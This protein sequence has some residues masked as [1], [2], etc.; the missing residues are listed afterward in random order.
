MSQ[1]DEYRAVADAQRQVLSRTGGVTGHEQALHP[2]LAAT[3]YSGT[4]PTDRAAADPVDGRR[5][6]RG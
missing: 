6:V 2:C 3:R 4:R 5:D 1:L